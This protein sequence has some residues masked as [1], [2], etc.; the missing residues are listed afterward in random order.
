[1]DRKEFLQKYGPH[2]HGLVNNPAQI[3]A[4]IFLAE[5]EISKLRDDV[6]GHTLNDRRHDAAVSAGKAEGI[7][8]FLAILNGVA[9]DYGQEKTS[10]GQ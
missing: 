1:M 5:Y 4:V 3:Q 10:S 6:H 8:D 7:K 9:R 2:I